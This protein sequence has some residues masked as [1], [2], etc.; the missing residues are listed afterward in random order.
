MI[1]GIG[2]VFLYADDAQ[3]LVAWYTKHLGIT[4]DFEPSERSFYRDFV[5]PLDQAYGR[6]EREVFAIRQADGTRMR[7]TSV[8]INLRVHG[9]QLVLDHLESLGVEVDKIEDYDYG[10]FAWLKDCEGNQL[11]L[12]QPR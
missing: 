11:E 5:L 3:S 12:F 4:F 2:G 1:R 7:S 10:R 9:L 8:V 6:Q